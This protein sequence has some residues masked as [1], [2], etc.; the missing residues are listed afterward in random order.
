MNEIKRLLGILPHWLQVEFAVY[1]CNDVKE[2]IPEEAL[3]ALG[4]AEKWLKEPH[5]VS[6]EELNNA[7]YAATYAAAYAATRAAYAAASA[8][9][10]AAAHATHFAKRKEKLKQYET[11]LVNMIANLSELEKTIYEV[12]NE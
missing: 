2:L 9:A 12:I 5:L 7:T 3:P 10:N 11:H 8:A 6:K 4:L 1:C